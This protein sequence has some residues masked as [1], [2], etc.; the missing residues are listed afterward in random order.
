M[1]SATTTRAIIETFQ[2][3]EQ[4]RA[5]HILL[6]VAPS[7]PAEQEAQV[8]AGAEALLASL[9]NGADFATL[10]QQH[11]EDTATAAQGGDLGY[12][13]RGQMVPPFE[14]MAFSLPVGQ[15]S[16]VVRT[17]FGWHILRVEDKREADIKPLADVELEIKDKL[18]QDKARDA[19]AAFVDD[20]LSAMEANPR[21]FVELARQHE[22]D[23]VTT[24]F[25]PATGRVEGLEGCRQSGATRFC[26]A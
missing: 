13:P 16:D 22:L 11:S 18:Q 10:A 7:A 25:I 5:R 17:P 4:V 8:R 14:E 15:V 24:P 23:V 12:F 20:L 6:K 3:Q 19:T 21:Q 2:R 1:R 9:R 26:P